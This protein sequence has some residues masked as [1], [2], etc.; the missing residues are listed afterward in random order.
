MKVL[1]NSKENPLVIT[2]ITEYKN[3]ARW[4]KFICEICGN[5]VVIRDISLKHLTSLTCSSCRRKNTLFARYGSST[6]NNPNKNRV[7]CLERYGIDNGSKTLE[8]KSKISDAIKRADTNGRQE[9]RKATCLRERGVDNVAKDPAVKA[10]AKSTCE[11]RYGGP[12]PYYSKEVVRKGNN[13]VIAKYGSFKNHPG[14]LAVKTKFINSRLNR[15]TSLD[16]EFLDGQEYKGKYYWNNEIDHG[17]IFYEFRCKIC[18]T[19][20]TDEFHSGNPVCRKCHPIK[21]TGMENEFYEFIASIYS[22]EIV[23][24]NRKIL[25]GKEIDVLLPKLNVGFEFD[26]LHWHASDL[27]TEYEKMVIANSKGIDLYFITD[28]EW[29]NRR[30]FVT[31]LIKRILFGPSIT[32]NAKDCEIRQVSAYECKQFLIDN[33]TT[34]APANLRIALYH[35]DNIVQVAT[36]NSKFVMT[37][38]ICLNTNVIDGTERLMQ[39]CGC[40]ITLC[41]DRRFPVI[42]YPFM[43]KLNSIKPRPWWFKKGKIKGYQFMKSAQKFSKYDNSKSSVQNMFDNGWQRWWDC[44]MDVQYFDLHCSK[45]FLP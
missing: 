24:H 44:G 40:N 28:V 34:I 11:K 8:A 41:Q 1:M 30:N 26:G 19:Q 35:N 4:Y 3:R 17:P 32:I 22:D 45:K 42:S 36:F 31:S 25:N 5:E 14:S 16:I 20:F 12:A 7:T 43:T 21:F 23:R 13:S 18:G 6:Y 37:N 10:A 29:T 33:T 9:K 39:K 38:T 27:K 15:L 2:S